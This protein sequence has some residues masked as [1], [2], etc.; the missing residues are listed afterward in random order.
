MRGSRWENL[1][2]GSR[3]RAPS[4]I[5]AVRR[6]EKVTASQPPSPVLHYLLVAIRT[7]SLSWLLGLL[8]PLTIIQEALA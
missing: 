3:D 7:A 4:R 5:V 8:P 2:T 1:P 6:F